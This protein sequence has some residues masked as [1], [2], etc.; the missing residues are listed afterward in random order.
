MEGVPA[1]PF[2]RT[3]SES[4]QIRRRCPCFYNY[5]SDFPLNRSMFRSPVIFLGIKGRQFID[6]IRGLFIIHALRK[7][8]GFKGLLIG[9]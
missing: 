5:R 9:V 2:E 7:E 8:V 4:N 1:S 6:S 3:G